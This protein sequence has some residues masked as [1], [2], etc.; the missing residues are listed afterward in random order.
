[1]TLLSKTRNSSSCLLFVLV[2]C[3]VLKYEF[4]I[5]YNLSMGLTCTMLGRRL[6]DCGGGCGGCI[7]RFW[8]DSVSDPPSSSCSKLVLSSSEISELQKLSPECVGYVSAN[9]IISYHFILLVIEVYLFISMYF[10]SSMHF[11]WLAICSADVN[12]NHCLLFLE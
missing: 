12:A 2:H 9:R 4:C 3:S 6:S 5:R 10:S 1:M 11:N 8:S 7:S